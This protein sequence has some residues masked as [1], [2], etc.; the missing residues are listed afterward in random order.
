MVGTMV[1]TIRQRG[2]SSEG[3]R[4]GNVLSPTSAQVLASIREAAALESRAADAGNARASAVRG[5]P[6]ERM[7]GRAI[8]FVG[9]GTHRSSDGAVGRRRRRQRLA[10]WEGRKLGTRPLLRPRPHRAGAFA[11]GRAL[12]GAGA[13]LDRVDAGKP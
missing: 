11:G 12:A 3:L 9:R 5:D 6:A 10:R 13:A 1:P 7:V 2:W 4:I 8:A